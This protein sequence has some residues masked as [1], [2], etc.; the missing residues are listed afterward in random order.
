M[1]V[2]DI[3][4]IIFIFGIFYKCFIS[5][6]YNQVVQKNNI[7]TTKIYICVDESNHDWGWFI[8]FEN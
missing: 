8:D 1:I 4:I 6:N 7:K 3:I 5:I 2:I